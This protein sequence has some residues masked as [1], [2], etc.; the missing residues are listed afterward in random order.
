[1]R[2]DN[3]RVKRIKEDFPILSG[4]LSY[5]DNAATTQKPKK[6]IE[7]IKIYYEKYN[8]NIHR[9]IY[10]LS[11]ESTNL[12][13]TSRKI[14]AKF[15]GANEG[16]IIF[17]RGTTES[18]NLLSR[19]IKSII[20][21]ERNE[22]VISAMEHHSNL[23]PWQ[24]FCKKNKMK[25]KVIGL[26]KDLTLDLNQAKEL[27]GKN[28][29]AVCITHV[30]NSLGIINPIKKIIKITK[31]AKALSIIDAAQSAPRM[32][33]DVKKLDCDFLAFSGHKMCG[34]TGIGVLYGKSELLEKLPPFHFGGDMAESVTFEESIYAK[35]PQKFE[36][37]TPNIAGAIGLAKAIKYLE[38]IGLENIQKWE[39]RL[40]SY[41]VRRIKEIG[42]ITVYGKDHCGIVSFNIEEVHPHDVSSILDSYN[43]AIRSGNHCTMPLMKLMGVNS[44]CRVSFYFYNTIEDI[45][46]LIEG[47][48]KIK[49]KFK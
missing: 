48:T 36:A 26:K 21:K 34:P 44:T 4:D 5:L 49:E 19:T 15:I 27:I 40:S 41:A 18:I 29:V 13:D 22:I 16:E 14:V 8:A 1:M 31:K 33:I 30:S 46:K 25:L 6:V 3:D 39:E 38:N 17:T 20:E 28:T 45:N 32:Q 10:K 37:G 11:E 47:L 43:I 23:I 35:S 9:G 24:E 12:Y 42:G 7:A 2:L